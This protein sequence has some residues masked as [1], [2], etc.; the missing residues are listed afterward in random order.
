MYSKGKI[1]ATTAKSDILKF[2]PAL[3]S[4]C[5]TIVK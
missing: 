4:V 1:N 3:I 5:K 2:T